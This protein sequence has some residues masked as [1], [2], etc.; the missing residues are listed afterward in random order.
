MTA[1]PDEPLIL[2][3]NDD[4]IG[5]PGLVAAAEAAAQI[6]VVYIAAPQYP[7]QSMG[8]SYPK[9]PDTGIVTPS[10]VGSSIPGVV[11]SFGVHGS[12]AQ[13]VS[14]AILEL[15]PRLPDLCISGV[16]FGENL[17]TTLTGSGTLGATF[18]ADSYGINSIAVSLQAVANMKADNVDW[19]ACICVA[20]RL[21]RAMLAKAFPAEVSILNVNVPA[22]AVPG[23]ESR[24]TVDSR[25]P[26]WVF[27]KPIRT[28]L[29]NPSSLP[30]TIEVDLDSLE[31]RSDVRALV[32]DG[33]IS[34][35]PIRNSLAYQGAW[36]SGTLAAFGWHNT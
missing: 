14:Y 24:L 4:G 26:Y 5:A 13:V 29:S 20:I 35:T 3:T 16:N 32:V 15:L 31:P 11:A 30:V 18:E 36:D 1:D 8:R 21:G 33:V 6:G 27:E 10:T 9:H 7:Q 23:C 25:Q 12:P 34:V 22:L 17:G 28:E 2:V 19:S